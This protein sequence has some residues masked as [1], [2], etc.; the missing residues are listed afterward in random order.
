MAAPAPSHRTCVRA[1]HGGLRRRDGERRRFRQL[2]L[3]MREIRVL[4]CV[5]WAVLLSA[6]V[7][8]PPTPVADIKALAGV[9]KGF[10]ENGRGGV[11][12]LTVTIAEDGTFDAI[13]DDG[14]SIRGQ[15]RIDGGRLVWRDVSGAHGAAYLY[16]GPARRILRGR[17]ADGSVPFEWS[18]P[19]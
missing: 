4:V 2:A 17:R 5:V 12:P 14:G 10:S 3:T 11:R 13:G 19:R 9:W 18:Q 7:T 6:C 1:Q 8:A 16:D 15:L